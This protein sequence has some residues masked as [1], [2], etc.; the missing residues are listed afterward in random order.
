MQDSTRFATTMIT[1]R[2]FWRK[3]K[4]KAGKHQEYGKW[5]SV[6]LSLEV[7]PNDQWYYYELDSK[8]Y[9]GWWICNPLRIAFF[10]TRSFKCTKHPTP[11]IPFG[12]EMIPQTRNSSPTYA[13]TIIP[14]E[15]P[16]LS[17]SK[18]QTFAKENGVT[19]QD[20][21][22]YLVFLLVQKQDW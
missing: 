12:A 22:I 17:I 6:D 1:M 8:S 21:L 9:I 20:V 4:A 15:F 13:E 11:K 16:G 10:S 14:V 19:M 7:Q 2:T 3:Q 5:E 18:I